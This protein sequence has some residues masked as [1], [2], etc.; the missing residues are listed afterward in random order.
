[1]RVIHI[2]V[3]VVVEEAA[4][5][6]LNCFFCFYLFWM[7]KALGRKVVEAAA[8]V[9]VNRPMEDRSRR[10]NQGHRCSVVSAFSSF[11]VTQSESLSLLLLSSS[12]VYCSF[13]TQSPEVESE[14]SASSSLLNYLSLSSLLVEKHLGTLF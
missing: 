11:S 6:D 14:S 5:V 8:A 10:V 7:R 9:V 12:P 13:D 2:S 4:A 1:M 3:Q